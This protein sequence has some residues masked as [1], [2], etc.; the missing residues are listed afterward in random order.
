MAGSESIFDF[1]FVC[2][3]PYGVMGYSNNDKCY[4]ELRFHQPQKL[5]HHHI[6][7]LGGG[8]EMQS[9]CF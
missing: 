3:N 2:L 9:F 1:G 7:G 6:H 4:K 5:L 8:V